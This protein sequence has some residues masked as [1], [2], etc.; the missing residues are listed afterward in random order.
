MSET[1]KPPIQC[2]INLGNGTPEGRLYAQCGSLYID[3]STGAL[4]QKRTRAEFNTGWEIVGGTI[5]LTGEDLVPSP[6]L[7]VDGNFYIPDTVAAGAFG[8]NLWVKRGSDWEAITTVASPPVVAS[9]N[10]DLR[11]TEVG[12]DIVDFGPPATPTLAIVT[13]TKFLWAFDRSSTADDDDTN[14][15]KPANL[16]GSDPGRW[17]GP[18][19][20]AADGGESGASPLIQIGTDNEMPAALQSPTGVNFYKK[21]D[22]TLTKGEHIQVA[23]SNIG[24]NGQTRSFLVIH[25]T[26]TGGSTTTLVDSTAD[27]PVDFFLRSGG[28]I[29]LYIVAGTGAGTAISVTG[30]SATTLTFGAQA[31]TV[32]ATSEYLLFVTPPID[33]AALDDSG[34]ANVASTYLI[35]ETGDYELWAANDTSYIGLASQVVD[36]S[37]DTGALIQTGGLIGIAV[38]PTKV[39]VA[40]YDKTTF[41]SYLARYDAATLAK[42][43][44]VTIAQIPHQDGNAI[45]YVPST[46][47]IYWVGR[48]KEQPANTTKFI[49]EI[50]PANGAVTNTIDITAEAPTFTGPSNCYYYAVGGG[51]GRLVCTGTHASDKWAYIINLDTLTVSANLQVAGRFASYSPNDDRMWCHETNTGADVSILDPVAGS[52]DSA[53]ANGSL[54]AQFAYDP[55][56]TLMISG[57]DTSDD[58]TL[59]LNE[60]DPTDYSVVHI[61]YLTEDKALCCVRRAFDSKNIVF[62]ESPSRYM[63]TFFEYDPASNAPANYKRTGLNIRRVEVIPSTGRM[64]AASLGTNSVCVIDP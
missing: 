58:G 13:E 8:S 4:W 61:G 41:E 63:S 28:R 21:T 23:L 19:G 34:T 56:T 29:N 6:S 54:G 43:W 11:T 62:C 49:Y 57:K 31:F 60:I 17:I 16:G 38:S 3:S 26:A 36:R 39:F 7:G 42:D 5:V 24:P 46:D 45:C 33:S 1:G 47:R 18:I 32:D 64:F 9:T 22:L 12:T 48:F 30:N 10:E 15:I 59:G 25:R 35:P 52:I 37:E 44:Q 51:N 40:G 55:S 20:A 2:Q 53:E 50:N 27:W 14:V